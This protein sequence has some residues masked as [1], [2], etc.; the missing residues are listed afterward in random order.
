MNS[1]LKKLS[2]GLEIN[3]LTLNIDKCIYILCNVYVKEYSFK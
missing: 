1:E 3:K 2:F